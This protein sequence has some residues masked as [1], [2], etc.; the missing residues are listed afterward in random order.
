M[1]P[2]LTKFI[3]A[4]SMLPVHLHADDATA[5]RCEGVSTGKT[6]AWHVLDAAP[7]ATALCGV[8]D[9]VGV[10]ANEAASATSAGCGWQPGNSWDGV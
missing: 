4:T 10:A 1:F 7:G 6:E 5:Q 9:G 2:V 3:D 8:R